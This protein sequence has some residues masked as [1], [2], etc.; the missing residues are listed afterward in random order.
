MSSLNAIKYM[1]MKTQVQLLAI[2]CMLPFS[3]FAQNRFSVGLNGGAGV[4]FL[5]ISNSSATSGIEERGEMGL[6]YSIGIQN[7]YG[8]ENSTFLRAGVH[9]QRSTFRHRMDGLRYETDIINGTTSSIHNNII[10]S[11]LG[12]PVDFGYAIRTKNEKVQY[13]IGFGGMINVALDNQTKASVFYGQVEEEALT[14]AE[15]KADVSIYSLGIFGGV[16]VQ[17][18][19]KIILGIEP[20]FRFTPNRFTLFLFNSEGTSSFEAGL[21][22]RIR[23]I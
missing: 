3:G 17:V 21:T 13:L 12:I 16:E 8:F 18:A 4:N 23:L 2:L 1:G 10:V 9:Y 11:A 5:A 14:L 15:N 6:G 22:L 20:T 7:Q 19:K